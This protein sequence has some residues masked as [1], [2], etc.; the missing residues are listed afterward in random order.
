MI[1]F[2]RSRTG[3]I[4]IGTTI[5]LSQ[6]LKQLAAEHGQGLEV[7]AVIDGSHEA[8]RCLHGR[9]AHLRSVGEWFEPGD[10]LLGFIVSDGRPWD[11]TDEVKPGVVIRNGRKTVMVRVYEDTA[12]AITQAAGER[13]MTAADF[14]ETFLSPCVEKAHREYIRAESEKLSS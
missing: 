13:R 6:R 11:G 4:K 10:D 9:F 3:R 8:E 14:C 5:R 7:L 1:Y 2:I 12:N